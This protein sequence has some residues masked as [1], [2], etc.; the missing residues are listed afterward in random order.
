MRTLDLP[1]ESAPY[2]WSLL[3]ENMWW[4]KLPKMLLRPDIHTDI[5]QRLSSSQK[6]QPQTGTAIRIFG[7]L[8]HHMFSI[9]SDQQQGADSCGRSSVRTEFSKENTGSK[10]FFP[11]VYVRKK[12]VALLVPSYSGQQLYKN[13][14]RPCGGT[15]SL[16]FALETESAIRPTS[17]CLLPLR[18]MARTRP[19]TPPSTSGRRWWRAGGSRKSQGGKVRRNA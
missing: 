3:I 17:L 8:I 11:C 14:L 7:N 15:R 19:W 2:C 5:N 1:Q 4:I 13:P 6:S 16:H 18:A 12:T 10:H 9:R